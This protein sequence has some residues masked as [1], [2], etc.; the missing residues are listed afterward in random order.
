M[1]SAIIILLETA[2]EAALM[3]YF[4]LVLPGVARGQ[5]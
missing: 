5:K 3:D 2:L 4:F 1:Q